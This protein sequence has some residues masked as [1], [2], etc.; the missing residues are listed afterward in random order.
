MVAKKTKKHN[1]VIN[2]SKNTFISVVLVLF[3]LIVFATVLTYVIPRGTF[4]PLVDGSGFDYTKYIPLENESGINIFKGLFSPILVLFSGDG[5]TVFMLSLFLLVISGAFQIINDTDGIKAIVKALISKFKDRKRLLIAIVI[6]IFMVFGAFLGLFEEVVTLLPLIIMLTISLGY[7]SYTGFLICI[8]A[9]GFGFASAITNPFTVITASNILGISPLSKVWFRF[10]VFGIMYGL[11]LL[12]VLLHIRKIEKNPLKSPTYQAD[13]DRRDSLDFNEVIENEK[14]ILSTYMVFFSLFLL[15]IIIC[16]VIEPLRGLTVVFLIALFLF[17]GF[18]A[19]YILSKDFKKIAK[20]FL[21]GVVSALPAV[22]LVLLAS[23][24]KYVLEEGQVI[25]TI[26][27]S[28]SNIVEGKNIYSVAIMIYVIILALELCISSSTAKAI[29]VMGIL[30]CVNIDLSKESLMLIYLF[31]DGY[32][33]VLFPTSPVL[34][35]GL[36]MIGM[37]YLSWVKNGKWLFI[38]NTLL[39]LMLI[40]FAVF[41]KY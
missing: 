9:A 22:F 25:A 37:N 41:I 5:L 3:S 40:C 35:I 18:I 12:Y 33:N 28:I 21:N 6:L 1:K 20:S 23:S 7:D 34:L 8:I 16:T 38:I 11:L 19:G 27:H 24:I 10:I 17:G 29:F 13:L 2:I 39:V 36:S 31:G 30:S 4:E 26:T 15:L 14:K 32:T